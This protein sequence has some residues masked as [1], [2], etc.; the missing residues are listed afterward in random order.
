[1]DK[2]D[3]AWLGLGP[4]KRVETG[5]DVGIA[6]EK[7]HKAVLIYLQTTVRQEEIIKLA[8]YYV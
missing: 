4:S 7:S 2:E 3:I 6:K 8:R 1:M 5:V